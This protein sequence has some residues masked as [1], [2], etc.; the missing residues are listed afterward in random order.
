MMFP[1]ILVLSTSLAITA[2]AT[3]PTISLSY[4]TFR[5]AVDGNL[6]TFLG[7]PFAKPAVRFSLPQPPTLLHGVQNATAF[8][9]ACPQQALS[10]LA[11]PF[12]IPD[13]GIVSEDCLKLNVFAPR[14]ISPDAKLP[15]FV[16]IYGGGFEIGNAPDTDVRPVVERSI[17]TG[18]PVIIV[19]PNY[20]LSAFGFLAGKEVGDEGITN[21]G[22]RDQIFALEWVREHMGAFGG[23]PTRVVI[24]GPSAGAISA[25]LLLLD[26]KQF[27]PS[28]LFRGAF[29]LSGSPVTTGS[30]ADGQPHY[31]KLIL[32][33][34]C[35]GS[36]D[37]LECLRRVPFDSFMATVNHTTNLFSFS[38]LQNIWRPRVDGDVLVHNPLVSVSKGLYAK[39]PFMTGDADDEGTLFSLS[40]TNITTDEE[41][42]GYIHSNYLPQSTP[43][44]IAQI[45]K[46]YPDDP[47]Q[48]S[49]FGTG[50]ENQFTPQFKRIAAFQGDYVFTGTRRFFLEHASKTQNTWSW[51]SKREKSTPVLGASHG[52]DLD[53]WFPPAN[54]TDFAGV[55]ALINFINTLDPNHSG[56]KANASQTVFWPK[57][58]TPT[59]DGS[60]SLLTFSDPGVVNVTSENFRVD[61]IQFLLGLLLE[62]ASG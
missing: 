9:P 12:A 24:G 2:S 21:L 58:N 7:V 57:W 13:E 17:A 48:G 20:R 37:T 5:G 60:P 4:G 27:E 56:T 11:L 53:I 55:D 36:S 29:M 45:A 6:S 61:A 39:V 34:N 8:G 50:L 46:L 18:E 3:S 40:N 54:S 38:S 51:L 1:L 31:D 15:V 41:F 25:A 33:N 22:V 52:S 32:A 49:P 59:L 16:W 19:T 10:P 26:N 35:T 30:V 28:A 43:A 14:E 62:E 47:T 23:D 42:V 44:Q